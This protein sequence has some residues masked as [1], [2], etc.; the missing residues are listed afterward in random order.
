MKNDI[1]KLINELTL[2]EKAAL[3]AGLDSWHTVPVPR[4]DIPSI[5]MT[6]GPHGVRKEIEDGA[7]LLTKQSSPAICYPTAAA[8]ACSW[9]TELLSKLGEALGD[10][11]L[12]TDISILLGPGI[13]IKRSP[14]CGRNFEYFS[15]DPVLAGKLSAGFINL[16]Q[17]FCRK[18]SG[19]RANDNGYNSRRTYLARDLPDKL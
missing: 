6:D 13:N 9:D 15:E 2:D 11:C 16:A 1:K 5:M 4:L 10:E 18:Q 7:D 14:L 3:C 19:N 8:L 17:A 12:A